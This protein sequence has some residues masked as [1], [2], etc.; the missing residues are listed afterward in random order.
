MHTQVQEMEDGQQNMQ[1]ARAARSCG[2]K[3]NR[4][5]QQIARKRAACCMLYMQNKK[6]D[7]SNKHNSKNSWRAN[8]ARRQ[9]AV[10]APS[11]LS[12]SRR[13]ASRAQRDD[14]NG[15][16]DQRWRSW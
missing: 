3:A 13:R 8:K 15:Q 11:E 9:H 16:G 6:D 14:R 5:Q 7:E 4:Q 2:P 10:P 12:L 1:N